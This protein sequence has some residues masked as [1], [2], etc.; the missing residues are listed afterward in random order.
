MDHLH[1]ALAYLCLGEL[2]RCSEHCA[3]G[4]R[5]A[6]SISFDFGEAHLALVQSRLHRRRGNL[7]AAREAAQ[8]AL[9]YST[10]TGYGRGVALG[11]E[12]LADADVASGDHVSAETR[13]R[14][15]LERGRKIAPAGDLVYEVSWRLATVL[16]ARGETSEAEALALDAIRLAASSGDRRE[17]GNA[18]VALGGVLA[19]LGQ[20]DAARSQFELG[21]DEF[22]RIGA[23]YELA[24]ALE[25]TG[26]SESDTTARKRRLEEA[27]RLY[28]D[29]GAESS[30]QRV[31]AQ[32]GWR[33][34]R[35]KQTNSRAPSVPSRVFLT[36]DHEVELLLELARD[37]AA[38]DATVLIEGETG[39]GKELVAHYLHEAGPRSAGP[40]LPVSCAEISPQ[41][42]ESELFGHQRGAFTGAIA[43]RAGLFESAKNGTLFLDEIDKASLEFQAKLLRVIESR[44]IRPVGSSKFR[45]IDARIVCA[46]N[47]DLRQLAE[48]GVFLEDLYYR[49]AGFL[50]RLPP[51]RHRVGDVELLT[52]H[53]LDDFAQRIDHPRWT[54]S[55]AAMS[56]LASHPWPGNVRELKN[57][58]EACAFRAR[59]ESAIAFEH[60]PDDL[61]DGA[62]DAP[63][64]TLP[65]KIAAFERRHIL[66]AMRKANGVKAEAARILGVSRK[67]LLDRLRRL[68]LDA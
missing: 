4:V 18:H 40:F 41:L 44:V 33:S 39:T 25:V 54:I 6:R 19:A 21:I 26:V 8:F 62:V 36:G 55:P 50:L 60:L 48:R 51:L 1:L 59:S 68:S 14:E 27:A 3:A 38:T 47:R 31:E 43:A 13:L 2:D 20:N 12:E 23:P 29:L 61:Q 58:I 42:I 32:L 46:T 63:N 34:T 66:D 37:L 11:L 15:A 5:S 65:D 53:F 17:L 24:T 52:A 16:V 10:R 64:A 30:C 57:V 49:L 56:A 45:E 35:P 22:R 28:R 67:G 7:A 9:D